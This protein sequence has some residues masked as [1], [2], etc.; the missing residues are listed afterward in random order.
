MPII[1]VEK[2]H[3]R[4]GETIAV[5]DV[6]FSVEPG[7]IFGILGPNGAGKTTTVECI[8]GL[9]RPDSGEVRVLGLQPGRDRAELA[10]RVGVQLQES[11]LQEKLKVR[12]ALD[13]YASFYRQPAD[14][15]ELLQMLGL[16]DKRET[17][18]RKLS[19]GQKQRL[20]IAMALI[21]N[22]EVAILDELTTG[23]DPQARRD[24]W[25]LIE[26]VR[27]RG[28]T[29]LLVTHF[30]DEAE[31]LCD[32]LA[33]IESGTVVATD[34]PAGLIQRVD[35]G[36]RVRFRPSAPV[37]DA[38]LTAIPDVTGVSRHGDEVVVTGSGNIVALMVTAL[39]GEQI[40]PL[41]VRVEQ[42]NLEDAFVALTGQKLIH[43]DHES[44]R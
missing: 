34:T 11:A 3:K 29:I 40:V 27:D 7:E 26:R 28:V 23:L 36:Q 37:D 16:Q 10:Q 38:L 33:L 25:E 12:E 32:R 35:R 42:A 2:L 39:A 21:G 9:R 24:T 8:E 18:Y 31:R 20:S 43:D 22:P 44:T 17:Y 41:D 14:G 5:D 13:L 4:Y 6:S 19:G 1:E 30:M 15:D